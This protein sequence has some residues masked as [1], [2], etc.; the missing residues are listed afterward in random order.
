MRTVTPV[1]YRRKST[2]KQGII[3]IR[4]TENR[5]N[6]YISL[7]KKIS[8]KYWNEN[9]NRVRENKDI[10]YVEL[11]G[12]IE[13]NLKEL[14]QSTK[15]FKTDDT[16]SFLDYYN[17][18]IGRISNEGSRIKQLTVKNKL[19]KYLATKHK[20]DLLYTE[21][22]E[23]FL[24]DL[25]KYFESGMKKETS[26]HYLKIIKGVLN[27]AVEENKYNYLRN[28]FLSLKFTAAKEKKVKSLSEEEVGKLIALNVKG[29]RVEKY[30]QAF[31][32]QL[33][34]QGMRVSDV[35]LIRWSNFENNILHYVMLKTGQDMY[36][37][38][39]DN[40]LGILQPIMKEKLAEIS[41]ASIADELEHDVTNTEQKLHDRLKYVY[42]VEMSLDLIPKGFFEGDEVG[43]EMLSEMRIA[44]ERLKL[45][46]RGLLNNFFSVDKDFR[47]KFVFNFLQDSEFENVKVDND[48][49]KMTAQQY[50][51]LKNN[52][53]VYNRNLK[54][55][56]ELAKIKT[57]L[58]THVARHTYT[59]LLMNSDNVN[60]YEISRSLGHSDVTITQNYIS[61]F[62]TARLD[63]L[64]KSIAEKY[65]MK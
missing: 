9:T 8:V 24:F 47:S 60:L 30:W 56:Q 50:R 25:K 57:K 52:S 23:D 11:N 26:N 33:F 2:E 16:L 1:L 38:I 46:Y 10:D 37:Y 20:K 55:V 15:V 53:I 58:T 61:R 41:K 31:M 36:V 6:T 59:S 39:N 63:K 27:K 43:K 3:K 5:K 35:Q 12:L 4:I 54:T 13:R 21:I 18:V 45:C 14:E 40:L 44:K 7:S 51:K 65:K 28:P 49:S 29:S 42:E 19:A 64:N 34:A 32:F 62:D 17:N 22:T 48:F